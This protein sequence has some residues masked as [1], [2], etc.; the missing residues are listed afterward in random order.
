VFYTIFQ[1]PA[2]GLIWANGVKQE[3]EHPTGPKHSAEKSLK[4]LARRGR[5]VTIRNSDEGEKR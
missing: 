2:G 3:R 5:S 4:I 1:K